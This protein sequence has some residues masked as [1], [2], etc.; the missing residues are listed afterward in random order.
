MPW[1]QA[2]SLRSVARPLRL[3]SRLVRVRALRTQT[4]SARTEYHPHPTPGYLS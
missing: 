4:E 2:R 3:F 1:G